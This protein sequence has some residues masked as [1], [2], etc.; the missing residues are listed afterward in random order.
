MVSVQKT[1]Q[2]R[3]AQFLV[4]SPSRTLASCFI[5][6]LA[7]IYCSVTLHAQEVVYHAYYQWVPFVLF[8]QVSQSYKLKPS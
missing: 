8:L 4:Y 3:Y 2:I 1:I 5:L 6:L 7:F